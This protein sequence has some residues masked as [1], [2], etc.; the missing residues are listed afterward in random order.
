LQ[1]PQPP[2]P[3]YHK[4]TTPAETKVAPHAADVDVLSV[5]KDGHTNELYMVQDSSGFPVS[6][7]YKLSDAVNLCSRRHYF[8]K[9][10]I[11]RNVR[12]EMTFDDYTI[13]MISIGTFPLIKKEISFEF[14][15]E[16]MYETEIKE[17]TAVKNGVMDRAKTAEA[18]L[19][20]IEKIMKEERGDDWNRT[21]NDREYDVLV[22]FE[23]AIYEESMYEPWG[24]L[25]SVPT[26]GKLRRYLQEQAMSIMR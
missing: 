9:R 26:S 20:S 7:F 11:W 15:P 5:D 4:M 21:L 23:D 18:S 10:G 6:I 25:S 8:V 16:S 19:M 1:N 3:S 17:Q 13:Q 24:R 12:H 22:L 14:A 2:Q